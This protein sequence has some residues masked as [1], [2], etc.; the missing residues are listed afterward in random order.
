MDAIWIMISTTPHRGRRWKMVVS[1]VIENE[2]GVTVAVNS[3]KDKAVRRARELEP[4]AIL[5][6]TMYKD[7]VETSGFFVSKTPF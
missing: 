4:N 2:N 5:I 3:D 7:G 6:G 1:Y